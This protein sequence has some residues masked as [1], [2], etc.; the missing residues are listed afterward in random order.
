MKWVVGR[1]HFFM[2]AIRKLNSVFTFVQIL[3]SISW[4]SSFNYANRCQK[5]S[6]PSIFDPLFILK[7]YLLLRVFY[8]NCRNFSTNCSLVIFLSFYRRQEPQ[9]THRVAT[10]PLSGIHSI[11]D[12]K[13][14]PGWWGW[15][16]HAHPLSL[17]LPSRTKLQCTLQ[18]R[19][20]YMHSSYFVSIPMYSAARKQSLTP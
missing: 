4:P 16:V 10:R 9:N 6:L 17:S 12:G 3:N 1:E 5:V 19:G 20:R 13:I 2:F 15:E 7:P 11:S 8:S 18:L 14:G